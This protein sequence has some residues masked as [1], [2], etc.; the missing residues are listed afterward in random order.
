MIDRKHKLNCGVAVISLNLD[1]GRPLT[2]PVYIN[3]NLDLVGVPAPARPPAQ[4][5]GSSG[6]HAHSGGGSHAHSGGG[7]HA[8]SLSSHA[9]SL[10]S[11]SAKRL[12][13]P[14]TDS[15]YIV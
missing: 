9:H 4:P 3:G 5:V 13:S 8:H 14:E 6:S 10:S 12:L 1:L 7:N 15:E 11:S 2:R